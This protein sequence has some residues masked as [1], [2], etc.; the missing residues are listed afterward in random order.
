MPTPCHVFT[1]EW[2][3]EQ[4]RKYGTKAE[5]A[6]PSMYHFWT[7][8]ECQAK[9]AVI[10]QWVDL[11]PP[12]K[13]RLVIPKL[14][15]T[16]QVKQTYNELAVADS[17]RRMGHK[18]E[19]EVDLLG[20]TPDWFV[21]PAGTGPEFVVEVLSSKPPRERERCDAG[22]DLFRR[23]LQSLSGDALL[24][25]QPSFDG[26]DNKTVT[27]PPDQRQKGIVRA[28]QKWLE[29]NPLDGQGWTVD[30]MVIWFV[31]RNPDLDHVV[32]GTGCMSFWIDGDPLREAIKEKAGKYREV[33]QT[34]RLP[35]VVCVVPDFASGRGLDELKEAVLGKER[36]R[37]IP[38]KQGLPHQE[39]YRDDDGLFAKYP[40]LSAVT[41][42]E[43]R[44]HTLA[45]TVLHNPSATY[46][47]SKEALPE[48]AP[49]TGVA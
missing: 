22:W 17:L 13:R 14:R 4:K 28:V 29:T 48:K 30:G 27:P 10:E 38:T 20:L 33:S 47:L 43:F 39:Y 42:G 9:R 24:Y 37:L 12:E 36:C 11:L 7:S 6:R 16:E 26:G 34:T 35:F 49:T 19:Y 46:P 8:E 21:R 31:G 40:T 1:P 2:V 41:L 3:A 15:T 44:G 32:C 18:V 45:H 23:R 5:Y 25:I